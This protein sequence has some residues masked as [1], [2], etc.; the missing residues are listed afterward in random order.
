MKVVV[1]TDKDSIGIG[2]MEAA[3]GMVLSG[4]L[5][6]LKVNSK[7]LLVQPLVGG[8]IERVEATFSIYYT[9]AKR[10]GF[11]TDYVIDEKAEKIAARERDFC[12]G[13][14]LYENFAERL[15]PTISE[16]IATNA[17]I[18]RGWMFARKVNNFRAK[19]LESLCRSPD[20]DTDREVSVISH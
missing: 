9:I 11:S 7:S 6:I 13:E 19:T 1:I 17:A 18:E 5:K 4:N 15:R 20:N 2:Y 12:Y 10:W 8:N 16:L 14:Y 3:V